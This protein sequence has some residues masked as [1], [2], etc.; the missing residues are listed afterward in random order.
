MENNNGYGTTPGNTSTGVV[1]KHGTKHRCFQLTL[2]N[3]NGTIDEAKV[4]LYNKYNKLKEYLTSLKFNYY[5]ACEEVN[6]KG[7]YHIHIYIQFNTPRR[8]S[9]KKCQGA[10]IETCKGTTT[11][12][13]NYIK[14][15]GAI[16]DE[17]G[18]PKLNKGGASIKEVL[19]C[20]DVNELLDFDYKYIRCINEIKNKSIQWNQPILKEPII[21]LYVTLE[22]LQA[23]EKEYKNYT[24]IGIDYRNKSFMNLSKYILIDIRDLESITR[25]TDNDEDMIIDAYNKLCIIRTLLNELALSKINKPFKTYNGIYYAN[26][27]KGI[28]IL[29]DMLD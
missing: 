8:L 14:K 2:N 18:T 28:L 27:V 25:N 24:A 19:N 21:P 26:D 29:K 11:E 9:V 6:K 16:I 15:D 17:A 22:Q 7:Y 10:H 3:E 5:I 13:I 4:E 23:N 1:K 12:N 20:S